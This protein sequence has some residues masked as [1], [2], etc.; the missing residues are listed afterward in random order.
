MAELTAALHHLRH[1]EPRTLRGVECHEDRA[2]QI[3][4]EYGNHRGEK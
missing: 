2:D 3:S 1:P 4:Q